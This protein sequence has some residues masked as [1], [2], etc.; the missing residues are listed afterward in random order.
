MHKA[1]YTRTTSYTLTQRVVTHPL[2][3]SSTTR[4]LFLCY[5][6]LHGTGYRTSS[7]FWTERYVARPSAPFTVN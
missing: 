3:L 7:I 5:L 4:L 6:D 1:R 2:R